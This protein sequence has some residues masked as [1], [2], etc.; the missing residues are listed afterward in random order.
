MLIAQK[1]GLKVKNRKLYCHSRPLTCWMEMVVFK[2]LVLL[3]YWSIVALMGSPRIML[4]DMGN[5]DEICL[6]YII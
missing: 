1:I 5:P 2:F 6:S 3:N 4:R